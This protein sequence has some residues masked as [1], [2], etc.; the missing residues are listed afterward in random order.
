MTPYARPQASVTKHEGSEGG[1]ETSGEH[2]VP[3][4]TKALS[5]P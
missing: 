2:N 1:A 3:N 5:L 4:R